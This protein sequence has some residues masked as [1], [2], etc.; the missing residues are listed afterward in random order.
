MLPF[1]SVDNS[2]R[3]EAGEDYWESGLGRSLEI[4]LG[5]CFGDCGKNDQVIIRYYLRKRTPLKFFCRHRWP[6]DTINELDISG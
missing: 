6:A 4:G 2:T 3:F 1:F 5:K